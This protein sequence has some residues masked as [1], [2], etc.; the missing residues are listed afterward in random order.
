M[1]KKLL[2]CLVCPQTGGHLRWMESESELWCVASGLAY[3]VKE[4]V[5]IMLVERARCLS[6]AEIAMLR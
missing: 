6:E 5:A 3:P 1:D 2:A 4:G